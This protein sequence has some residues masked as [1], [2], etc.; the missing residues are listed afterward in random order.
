[1]LAIHIA[2]RA[3]FRIAVYAAVGGKAPGFY[4]IG[5][6]P[7]IELIGGIT[8]TSFVFLHCRKLD[9]IQSKPVLNRHSDTH[10]IDQPRTN[11]HV[12]KPGIF[13]HVGALRRPVTPALQ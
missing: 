7:G 13:E 5:N 4:Q 6:Q 1:L 12:A 9:A 11:M 8:I 3:G 10:M 2:A